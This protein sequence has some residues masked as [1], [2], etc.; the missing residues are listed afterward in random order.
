[1][2]ALSSGCKTQSA[3]RRVGK[4][5][6]AV[7]RVPLSGRRLTVGVAR[8]RIPGLAESCDANVRATVVR[9]VLNCPTDGLVGVMPESG[10]GPCERSGRR[11][12]ISRKIGIDVPGELQRIERAPARR[13]VVAAEGTKSVQA[14]SER[15]IVA[16]TACGDVIEGVMCGIGRIQT[17]VVDVIVGKPNRCAR[18]IGTTV[19]DDGEVLPIKIGVLLREKAR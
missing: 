10:L 19:P 18:R 8:V 15:Y 17:R 2:A 1:M 5:R 9:G 16:I 13:Q 7:E 12:K 11:A 4:L 3:I 14:L 6:S